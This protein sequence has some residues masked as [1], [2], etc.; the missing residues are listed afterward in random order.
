MNTPRY[1]MQT[2]IFTA[3]T[4]NQFLVVTVLDTHNGTVLVHPPTFLSTSSVI[5]RPTVLKGIEALREEEWTK[6]ENGI[7]KGQYDVVG[8]PHP[9]G[10]K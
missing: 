5:K 10:S 8:G 4:G 7:K 1:T 3:H 6:F 2:E 9:P